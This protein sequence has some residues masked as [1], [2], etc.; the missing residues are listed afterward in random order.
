M[1]FDTRT[2]SRFSEND[3]LGKV[4][5]GEIEVLLESDFRKYVPEKILGQLERLLVDSNDN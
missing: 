2:G 1:T 4:A 5:R 3:L